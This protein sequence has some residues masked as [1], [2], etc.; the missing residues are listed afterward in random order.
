M[1]RPS[2]VAAS[3]HRARA[4][5]RGFGS[6]SRSVSDARASLPPAAS[7][8]CA[9]YRVAMF[10]DFIAWTCPATVSKSS[11]VCDG[12]NPCGARR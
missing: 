8:V 9:R 10:G 2:S 7:F 5:I 11:R 6:L 12:L 1:R 4:W 3:S